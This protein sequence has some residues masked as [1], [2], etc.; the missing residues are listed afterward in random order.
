[1]ELLA[2]NLLLQFQHLV[3]VQKI[4]G[5]ILSSYIYNTQVCH[6]HCDIRPIACGEREIDSK[7]EYRLGSGHSSNMCCWLREHKTLIYVPFSSVVMRG[8]WFEMLAGFQSHPSD[9]WVLETAS[10]WLWCGS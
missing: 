10:T 9:F 1:L 7:S 3:A 5:H 4:L 6:E 2:S 8:F